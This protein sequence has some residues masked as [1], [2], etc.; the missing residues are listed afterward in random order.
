VASRSTGL[1]LGPFFERYVRGTEEIDFGH[2]AELAGLTF[3]PKPKRKD[4]EEDPS[5]PGYL[6]I[7]YEN[8]G[9]LVRV[10]HVLVETPGRQAGLTPGD[11]IVAIN[12]VKVT[13][14]GFDKV[15]KRYPPATPVDLTVFRRG[16]LRRLPLTMGKP[17]PEAYAF[18]PSESPTELAKSVYESW[19]GAKWERPPKSE[20]PRPSSEPD[21]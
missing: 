13:F 5:E 11:E 4:E 10:K 14:E 18:S 15:L 8:S 17:P 3:G 20:S 21:H 7:R 12:N 6:G 2:F 1:D 16:Y 19:V 9:G